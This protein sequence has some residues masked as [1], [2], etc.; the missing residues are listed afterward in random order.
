MRL[1]YKY[2]TVDAEVHKSRATK[3]CTV[4]T[5]ICGSS[6]WEPIRVFSSDHLCHVMDCAGR[7]FLVCHS[8]WY[9]YLPKCLIAGGTYTYQSV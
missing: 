2:K 9:V 8:R 6:A 3:V 7:G 1:Y 4:A 5:N